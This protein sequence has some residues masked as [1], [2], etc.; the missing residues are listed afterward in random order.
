MITATLGKYQHHYNY[1]GVINLGD[2]YCRHYEL[3]T[4]GRDIHDH[5]VGVCQK[6]GRTV[7]YT[8]LRGEDVPLG[9]LVDRAGRQRWTDL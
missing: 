7:D 6:C 5:E 4:K 1:Q 2:P 3:V 8:I 9:R